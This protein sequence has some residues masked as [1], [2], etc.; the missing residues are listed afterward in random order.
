MALLPAVK[1]TADFI[2]SP[3]AKATAASAAPWLV[4]QEA[5]RQSWFE[6]RQECGWLPVS[7]YGCVLSRRSKEGERRSLM[8]ATQRAASMPVKT[9]IV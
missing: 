6:C 1:E 7:F 3:V 9:S 2:G 8:R 4:S 5:C